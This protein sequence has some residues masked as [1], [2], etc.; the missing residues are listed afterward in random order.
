MKTKR[1]DETANRGGQSGLYM[2]PADAGAGLGDGEGVIDE[3]SVLHIKL[4]LNSVA[5]VPEGPRI[6]SEVSANFCG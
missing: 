1:M 6:V 3:S 4:K 5:L 2:Y